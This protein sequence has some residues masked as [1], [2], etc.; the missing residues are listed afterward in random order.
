MSEKDN[1]GELQV[2]IAD[3]HSIVRQ[4][5]KQIIMDEFSKAKVQEASTGN[6][7]LEKCRESNFDVII[8]DISMPGKNGL[9][10]LKQLRAESIKNPVLILSM[11]SE[12]QYA[13]RMLKAGASGYLTKET[14]SEELV[15][16]VH[17]VLAG[18]KYITET[19]AEQLAT[20]FDN[21]SDKPLHQLITDREFQVLCLIATGKTVSEIAEELCLGVPTI[22]TYRAR[23]LEKM[24]LKNN[25]E[26]THYAIQ[27]GI[28]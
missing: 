10:I 21:P 12:S 5:L 13:V 22:S 18:R 1:E 24:S 17:R 7:T 14:A 8:L 2:L 4:G 25:A 9:E 28:V 15:A 20:D 26:L 3:D 19:L 23:I 6:Q 11:H 27:H 16:A